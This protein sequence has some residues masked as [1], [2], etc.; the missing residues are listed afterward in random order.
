M[1]DALDA[2]LV[3]TSFEHV[4]LFDGDD[5]VFDGTPDRSGGERG[6][7]LIGDDEIGRI[8][9]VLTGKKCVQASRGSCRRH[10]KLSWSSRQVFGED[11]R[12]IRLGDADGLLVDR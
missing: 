1:C 9:G 6:R 5:V 12:E 7:H 2:K 10:P 8:G 4:G 11:V 3:Q